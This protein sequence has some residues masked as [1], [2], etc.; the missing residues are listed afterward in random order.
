ME[1]GDTIV[2]TQIGRRQS[3]QA[4]VR[5]TS[6][7]NLCA[8]LEVLYQQHT[9]YRADLPAAIELIWELTYGQPW[10]VNAL[11]YEVCFKM[12]TGRYRSDPITAEMVVEAKERLILHR[13]IHIDQLVDKLGEER[14]QRVISPMLQGEN[15]DQSASHDDIQ[16]VIDLGLILTRRNGFANCQP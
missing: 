1:C 11:G 15:L 4:A 9:G 12:E 8:Y 16:Y 7:L 14:V 10:L 6:R 13:E 3:L 2:S 5:L